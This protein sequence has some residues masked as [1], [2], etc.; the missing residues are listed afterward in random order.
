MMTIK[1]ILTCT[2]VGF[3]LS[4]DVF[5]AQHD[6]FVSLK[7]ILLNSKTAHSNSTIRKNNH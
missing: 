5:Q 2:K 7:H 6:D 3:V 1:Y 4:D